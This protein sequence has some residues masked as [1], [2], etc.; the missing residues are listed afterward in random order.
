MI[1]G[2]CM[3]LRYSKNRGWERIMMSLIW[4]RR[5]SISCRFKN[6]NLGSVWARWKIRLARLLRRILMR[7]NAVMLWTKV[8]KTK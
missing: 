8:I 1:I 5:Q 2:I 4:G 6:S 3:E 7:A